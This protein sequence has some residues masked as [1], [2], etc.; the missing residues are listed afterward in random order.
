MTDKVTV[1]PILL[2]H[3]A[4]LIFILCDYFAFTSLQNESPNEFSLVT[5]D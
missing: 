3:F 5:V 2:S 1:Y 4:V